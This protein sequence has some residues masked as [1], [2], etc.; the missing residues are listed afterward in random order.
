MLRP[1]GTQHPSPDGLPLPPVITPAL[2]VAGAILILSGAFY[3]MIGIKTK[4]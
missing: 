3:T 2:S 4:R 1:I